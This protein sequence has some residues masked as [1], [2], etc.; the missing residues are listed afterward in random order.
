[1]NGVTKMMVLLAVITHEQSASSYSLLRAAYFMHSK[2]SD[3]LGKLPIGETI[4]LH[5]QKIYDM[6]VVRHE[7]PATV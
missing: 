3:L 6:K 7:F 5:P 4:K 2:S 1:M